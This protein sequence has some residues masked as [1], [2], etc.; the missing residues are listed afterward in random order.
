MQPVRAGWK[1]GGNAIVPAGSSIDILQDERTVAQQRLGPRPLVRSGDARP[2]VSPRLAAFRW[3]APRLRKH[4]T[5]AQHSAA[6]TQSLG[7]P[8]QLVPAD[9]TAQLREDLRSRPQLDG[10]RR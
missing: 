2:Q 10:D 7:R 6:R 5:P 4:A 3:I 9:P 8:L 1:Y